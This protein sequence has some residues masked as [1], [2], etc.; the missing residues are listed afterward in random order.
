MSGDP[1]AP[2]FVQPDRPRRSGGQVAAMVVGGLV[3]FAGLALALSAA[4]L[5]VIVGTDGTVSTARGPLATPTAALVTQPATLSDTAGVADVLGRVRLHLEAEGGDL[6][7]GVGRARRVERYLQGVAVDEVDD[8]DDLSPLE[9]RLRRVPGTGDARPPRSQDLWVASATN[10]RLDWKVR[11]GDFRIVLMN[12]D[13]K[14][15]VDARGRIGVEV[16]F[17]P[18]AGY[19]VL[20]AGVLVLVLGLAGAIL[21]ARRPRSATAAGRT[22]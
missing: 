19:G 12:A 16:P 18:G 9:L 10:G 15:G 7:L 2:V 5:L 11:D 22:A 4:A 17:L 14:A 1:S 6:F 3:A 20:G 21:A 8:I 13:G